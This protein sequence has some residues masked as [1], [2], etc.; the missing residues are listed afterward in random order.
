MQGRGDRITFRSAHR[1][2]SLRQNESKLQQ[3]NK[4]QHKTLW[5]SCP[6]LVSQSKAMQSNAKQSN[7]IESA[8]QSEAKSSNTKQC[9]QYKAMQSNADQNIATRCKTNQHITVAILAECGRIPAAKCILTELLRVAWRL[10]PSFIVVQK[11]YPCCHGHR[12]F[13]GSSS[14]CQTADQKLLEC[15]YKKSGMPQPASR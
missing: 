3:I 11:Q 1:E 6:H 10:P 2:S 14:Q 5:K 8:K 13:V 7:T 9:K 4:E 12:N 15:S